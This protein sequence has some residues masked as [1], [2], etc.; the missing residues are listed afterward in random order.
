MSV[1]WDGL[2][3]AL[4][5]LSPTLQNAEVHDPT[6]GRVVLAAQTGLAVELRRRET[7]HLIAVGLATLLWLLLAILTFADN[8]KW[9]AFG[10]GI[11]GL[12]GGIFGVASAAGAWKKGLIR[13]VE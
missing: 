9:E 8:S 3:Q 1:C 6:T 10:G 7:F 2:R 13:W 4:K 12:I 5:R 11:P